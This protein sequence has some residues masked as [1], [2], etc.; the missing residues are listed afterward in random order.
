MPKSKHSTAS[1]VSS[2][3]LSFG[4]TTAF[5]SA[6]LA[7]MSFRTCHKVL[8][9]K[10]ACEDIVL[11]AVAKVARARDEEGAAWHFFCSRHTCEAIALAAVAKVAR[12]RGEECV[13]LLYMAMR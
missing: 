12:A 3:T 1:R 9:S 2:R 8:C 4:S 11:A 13:A 7:A 6:W 5:M 10:H